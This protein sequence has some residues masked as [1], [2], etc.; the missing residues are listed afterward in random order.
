MTNI[1]EL[2]PGWSQGMS[3]DELAQKLA[4]LPK[5]ARD[6]IVAVAEEFT[7]NMRWIPNI[8][9]QEA[10][11]F[12]KADI[13]LWGGSAGCGKSDILLGL[14]ATAHKKSLIMRAQFSDLDALVDRAIQINGT[15][16]GFNGSSPPSLRTVDGRLVIFTGATLEKWQ[17]QDFDLK[18]FDE[19]VQMQKA[20]ID[21]HLGWLRTIDP[22]QRTRAVLATNPPVNA[23]GDWIIGMFRPWLDLTHENPAKLG[24]LRWYCKDPDGNDFEVDG[25]QPHQ[26]PGQARPVTPMSRTFIP[27][28]LN[29]NPYLARTDYAAKLDNLPEPLRSAVRDGNFMAARTDQEYQVIPTDWVMAAQRRWEPGLESEIE[30]TAIGA[31]VGQGGKD[32][33]V[34]APRHGEWYAPLITVAGKKAPDGSTQAAL[35]VQH[36]RDNAAVVVDVGGGYG[37]DCCG[38]LEANSIKP[39][40]F[41]GSAGTTARALD[42][43]IFINRRAEAYWRFREALNP[44]QEGGSIVALPDDP[45]IRAELT[46]CCYIPDVA[47]IQVESKIDVKKRLGR[48]PDKADA[49]VMAWAPGAVAKR[50]LRFGGMGG[51]ER[52]NRASVGFADV[53]R[54]FGGW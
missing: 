5:G 43:R 49:I 3:L 23:Q 30:M 51:E 45:E 54:G 40:K 24:E 31:D 20:V 39:E 6:E 38:R 8:G 14:A 21:F 13:L 34:L 50:R 9:A 28:T 29:D 53:K 26:F 22:N 52:P 2:V 17:G 4:E 37:G 16:V 11:F 1:T 48:S 42:G 7:A 44:D 36:R 15:K 10:A 12:C 41:N 46:A 27:G 25:P 19:V 47:K 35:I 33:V 18:G 32:R